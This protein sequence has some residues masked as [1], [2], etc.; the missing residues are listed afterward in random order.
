MALYI[1]SMTRPKYMH[2]EEFYSTPDRMDF[3]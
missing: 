2:T 3:V 1:P